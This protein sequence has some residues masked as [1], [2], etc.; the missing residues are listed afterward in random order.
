M[1]QTLTEYLTRLRIAEARR[2]LTDT[3]SPVAEI[4]GRCGFANLSNFNRR[5]R[6]S[7]GVAPR[8][9]RRLGGV[10]P[11]PPSPVGNGPSVS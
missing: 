4:A 3:D 11:H 6:Q 1:G 7:E 10:T 5:F 8:D 9:Y 2:L